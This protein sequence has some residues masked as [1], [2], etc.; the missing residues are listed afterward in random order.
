[1][2]FDADLKIRDIVAGW[3]DST[4][5]AHIFRNS[6]LYHRLETGHFGNDLLIG[7]SG[8][9]LESY[10]ITP[11]LQTNSAGEGL[12]S[13]PLL[14]RNT[15]ERAYGVWKRYFPALRPRIPACS[16]EHTPKHKCNTLCYSSLA[17]LP[18]IA[19][20]ERDSVPP[21]SDIEEE[22]F[23]QSNKIFYGALPAI[24]AISE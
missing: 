22:A 6:T 17:T 10:L 1:M 14:T 15:V 24:G 13:E 9:P 4:H 23:V 12:L 3:P 11:L 20:A 8:Y 18:N 7:D 2:I 16:D 21:A 19:R 5:E